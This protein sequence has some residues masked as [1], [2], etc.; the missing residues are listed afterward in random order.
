M[1]FGSQCDRINVKLADPIASA[2][3]AWSGRNRR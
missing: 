1:P 2:G 3:A